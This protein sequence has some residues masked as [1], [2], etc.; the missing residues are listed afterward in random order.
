MNKDTKMNDKE[1]EEIHDAFKLFDSEGTGKINVKKM[2]AAMK[3]FEI[4]K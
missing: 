4:N 2:K 1:I 3:S